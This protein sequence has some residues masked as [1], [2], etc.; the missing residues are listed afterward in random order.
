VDQND[1][2]SGK[3][4]RL[5]DDAPDIDRGLDGGSFRDLPLVEELILSIQEQVPRR[6]A[7]RAVALLQA[8]F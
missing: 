4:K 3:T 8:S 5:F 6:E 2:G 7:A 1:G